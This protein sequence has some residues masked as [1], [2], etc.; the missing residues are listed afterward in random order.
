MTE[1]RL[2]LF[3]GLG[4]DERLYAGQRRAFRNLLTPNYVPPRAN[5]SIQSYSQRM[6][7]MVDTGGAPVFV[8]GLS[9]GAV[10]ALEAAKHL[11]NCAGVILISGAYSY[12]AIAWPFRFICHLARFAPAWVVRVGMPAFPTI[13]RLLERLNDEHTALYA[14][15][16]RE[17]PPE[18]IRWSAASLIGWEY[19]GGL[20]VPVRAIHGAR[21]LIIPASGIPEDVTIPDGRHLL[22]LS[23]PEAV[24]RFIADTMRAASARLKPVG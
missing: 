3:P 4:A 20:R 12:R 16:A 11:P 18:L 17:M 5:E 23:H 15:L 9:F 13:L 22:S 21:D 10:V 7:A 14:R 1:P 19:D 6:A 8:G 24:N 2:I